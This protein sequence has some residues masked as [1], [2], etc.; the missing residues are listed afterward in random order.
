[1]RF[2]L[3]V[4]AAVKLQTMASEDNLAHS[5]A[6]RPAGRNLTVT[7]LRPIRSAINAVRAF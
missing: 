7:A 6:T 5:S 3:Y 2:F 4:S 1:M